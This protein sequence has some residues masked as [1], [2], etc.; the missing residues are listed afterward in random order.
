MIKFTHGLVIAIWLFTISAAQAQTVENFLPS[1]DGD[2]VTIRYDLKYE[3]ATQQ[4]AVSFY[5]S[6]D[7]Y[8]H[9]LRSLTGDYGNN[10][11]PG[12]GKQVVWDVKSELPANFDQEVN[13][14]IRFT[15]VEKPRPKLAMSPFQKTSFRKGKTVDFTWS[16]GASGEKITIELLKNGE[17]E[18]TIAEGHANSHT[19]SW[20]IPKKRRSGKGYIVRIS[21]AANTAEFAM[22]EPFAIKA[23]VPLGVKL[24]PLAG[25]AFLIP[26]EK[27]E[28]LPGP[29]DPD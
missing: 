28:N 26:G 15:K 20:I 7:N 3:D 17:V 16:G 9:P 1:F 5:S 4:F 6:H 21:N 11:F 27:V 18:S 14:R 29:L 13:I 2:K 24:L 25:L 22:S 10:I 8:T 19:F 12:K 23:T